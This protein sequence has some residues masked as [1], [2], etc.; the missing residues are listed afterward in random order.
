MELNSSL[1]NEKK[2]D[3]KQELNLIHPKKL[4]A[5]DTIG[6]IAPCGKV[7]NSEKIE[8]AVKFFSGKGFN[9]KVSDHVLDKKRYLAGED[10]VRLKELYNFFENPKIDAIICLRGG[11]GAIRLIKNIDYEIIK[12]NPKI[13]CGFSDV[14]ALLLMLTKKTGLV[15]YHAPMIQSDFGQENL[16]EFTINNFFNVF[17]S[18]HLE[19]EGTKIYKSGN[20]EGILW[21][22]NLSTVVTLCGQDFLPD[23]DFIFFTEDLN[24]NAYKIDRM[25]TQLL[26]IDKFRNNIKGLVIGDFIETDNEVFVN[27]LIQ[28]IA[29][30]LKI[31]VAGGFKITHEKQKITLPIGVK[32]KLEGLKLII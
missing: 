16:D 10:N 8:R 1:N 29:E 19:F 27:E 23:E 9:V 18:D 3:K 5:G 28:E 26:N 12:K 32:A 22:G 25:F 17:Q 20:C 21:G 30:N 4:K 14:T 31:P 7:D 2:I 24:E 11:Y 15:T 13:F 6:I